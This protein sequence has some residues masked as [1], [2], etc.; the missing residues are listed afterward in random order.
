ME[1]TKQLYDLIQGLSDRVLELEL[2]LSVTLI[3]LKEHR[4]RDEIGGPAVLLHEQ[5]LDEPPF[6]DEPP[7][8]L[9]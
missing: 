8:E 3:Q 5:Q 1:D 2:Q 6:D 7:P 4:H 9:D